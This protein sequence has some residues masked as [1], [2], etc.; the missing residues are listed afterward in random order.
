MTTTIPNARASQSINIDQIEENIDKAQRC[1]VSSKDSATEAAAHLYA[2]WDDTMSPFANADA[3]KWIGDQIEARNKEIDEH[4]EKVASDRK[5]AKAFKAGTLSKDD[6]INTK[7]ANDAGRKDVDEERAKLTSLAD[8]TDDEWTARRKVLVKAQANS[9]PFTAIVKFGLNF[10]S[11]VHAS[12]TSR[13]ATVLEWIHT[14]FEGVE[15]QDTS[16]I[17]TAIKDAGGFEMVLIEQRNK[18][19]SG[20][21]KG[22][23]ER[24]IEAEERKIIE[25]A[26]AAKAK[27]A[28][29]TAPAIA[30][31]DMQISNANQ[32]I[33]VLIGRYADGKVEV[34]DE[35]P[36]EAGEVDAM[37]S[38][39]S[40]DLLP[41]TNE[42]AEFVARVLALGS[43]VA[44]GK[45]TEKPR[46][47]TVM[48]EK[49]MEQRT[50]SLLPDDK[51]ITQLVI[52]A[53]HA[54]S[55]AVIKATPEPSRVNLGKVYV[56]MVMAAK[57]FR[58]LQTM[59]GDRISRCLTDIVAD[60][61]SVSAEGNSAQSAI[62]WTASNSALIDKQ[63]PNGSQTFSWE[64]MTQHDSRPL[65]VDNFHPQFTVSV[66][67][68]DMLNLYRERLEIW[69][70]KVDNKKIDKL[71]TLSFR[72]TSMTYK[73]DGDQDLETSC[74]GTIDMPV[75]LQFRPH[76][77]HDLVLKLTE[78]HARI[79]DVSG[80]ESGLFCVSWSDHLGSYSV[81]LPTSTKDGRLQS[82]RVA[83]M[84]VT[85][86][87]KQLAA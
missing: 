36:L 55:S 53:L 83:P 19:E 69:H 39:V 85:P 22:A 79:F 59:L 23:E 48:G 51:E 24:E 76:D 63:H 70:G 81:Y 25:E 44:E 14:R 11:P 74:V 67:A 40:D 60:D 30:T 80:D 2:V 5:R 27:A 28:V 29:Q 38:R 78:Q 9:S 17:V 87:A 12:V 37:V 6:L 42:T 26:I 68:V 61:G 57:S 34:V 15:I 72:E 66:S 45:A 20:G 62:S 82:R 8:L 46:D 41:R 86:S 56:P 3:K 54:D 64:D 71:M 18:G 32:D 21:S 65:D 13:Y 77:L 75:V 84:R 31:I 10:D 7:P 50:L 1:F 49:L 47:G 16:E 58:I 43:I 73:V 35:I 52:S 33:V 4:N